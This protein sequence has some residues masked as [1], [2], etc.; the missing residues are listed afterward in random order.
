LHIPDGNWGFLMHKTT[1]TVQFQSLEFS[2]TPWT[3]WVWSFAINAGAVLLLVAIPVT[4]HE[5]IQ[6]KDRVLEVS[7]LDP[8]H[9][10][11]VVPVPRLLKPAPVIEAK[12]VIEVKPRFQAPVVK[13]LPVKTVIVPP[14]PIDVPKPVETAR[15]EV[16]KIE[17][18]KLV[19]Q[20]A[21]PVI[22][23][24]LKPVKTGGFGDPNG[25]PAAATAA[26]GLTLQ[27]VGSFDAP[28]GS[29]T[30]RYGASGSGKAV[31]MAGFGSTEGVA[32][33]SG[34]N[35][36]AAV[37]GSGFGDYEAPVRP[38]STARPA[39]ASTETPVEITFKPKP[40]YT[41]EAREKKIE[42]EVQ[43][44]VLFSSN[45]EVHVL[46]VVRGLGFGLDENARIAA[47]Q[48]RFRPATRSGNP[49][50]VTGIVHIVFETS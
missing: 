18:P 1:G 15:L 6:P 10:V 28:V 3:R 30:S 38:V 42:G 40:A 12:P 22:Q 39:A 9:P 21:K 23:Q 37:S 33:G 26:K 45:G 7:L 41:A 49:V 31:A 11:T 29:G 34:G 19:L 20:E 44:D 14:V 47:G 17:L 46:R 48:I 4:V 25:V 2:R 16:P 24:P 13:T 5:V 8:P 43:L 50:D 32:G 36:R 27:Q 35:R